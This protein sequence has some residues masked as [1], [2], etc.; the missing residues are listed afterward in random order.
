LGIARARRADIAAAWLDQG[1]GA[2]TDAQDDDEDLKSDPIAQIDLAVSDPLFRFTN[3]VRNHHTRLVD[4]ENDS[5]SNHIFRTK[6]VVAL[7]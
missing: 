7:P 2:D 4:H 3:A 5:I 6:P 1:G